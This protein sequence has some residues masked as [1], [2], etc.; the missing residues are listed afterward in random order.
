MECS[1]IRYPRV[2]AT[3]SAALMLAAACASAASIPGNI[4][5]AVADSS[6]PEAHRAR[7]AKRK[8]AEVSAFTGVKAGAQIAE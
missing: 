7:D 4:A 2:L 8:P 6:R 5:A 3:A 1:V